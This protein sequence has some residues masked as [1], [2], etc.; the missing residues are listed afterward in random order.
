MDLPLHPADDADRLAEIDLGMARWMPQRHKHLALPQPAL[1]HIVLHDRQPTGVAVLVPQTL[2][3]PLRS[4]PLLCRAAL[5][6]LQDPVDD[7]DK[8]VQLRPC[9]RLAPPISRRHRER[10]HLGY[11]P[12]VDPK[13]PRRF[14]SAQPLDLDRMTDPCI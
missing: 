6:L 14:A 8:R 2:E 5:I 13:S 10:H 7:P 12:R 3:D 4:V 11:R 1:V 9:R